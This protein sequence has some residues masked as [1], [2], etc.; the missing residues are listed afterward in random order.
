MGTRIASYSQERMPKISHSS[1]RTSEELNS[2][3]SNN[4]I[5]VRQDIDAEWAGLR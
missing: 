5:G 1:I 4:D 3:I 2:T